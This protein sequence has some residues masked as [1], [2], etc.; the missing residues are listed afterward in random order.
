MATGMLSEIPGGTQKQ[1]DAIMKDLDIAGNWP[2][3][4]LF[5]CASAMDNGWRVIDVWE[6]R[7]AFEQFLHDR[8]MPIAQR[9]GLPP[10]EPK[11]FDVHNLLLSERAKT[12]GR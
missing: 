5:H 6:S 10:F 3:G 7:Q 11:Y 9:H 12:V 1:Y 4:L 2:N 8:L